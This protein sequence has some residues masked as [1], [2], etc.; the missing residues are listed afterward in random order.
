MYK[1]IV[2][3][4]DFGRHERIND[5]VQID[6]KKGCLRSNTTMRG[7]IIIKDSTIIGKNIK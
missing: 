1:I 2:N 3:A 4:D 6:I 7:V 5:A